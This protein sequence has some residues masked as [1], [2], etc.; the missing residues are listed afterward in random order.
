M[1]A[2]QGPGRW[3]P[4]YRRAYRFDAHLTSLRAGSSAEA[5]R[6]AFFPHDKQL[7]EKVVKGRKGIPQ[8]LKPDSFCNNLLHG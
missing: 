4:R 7:A 5:L 1:Q 3:G 2:H 6:A 8:R